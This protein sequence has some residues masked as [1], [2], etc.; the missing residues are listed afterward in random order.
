MKIKLSAIKEMES[1]LREIANQKISIRAAYRLMLVIEQINKC[2][3]QI[4]EMRVRLVRQ[5]GTMDEHGGV[6]VP[7]ENFEAFKND[8][9]DLLEEEV[10]I[11]F[12]KISMSEV[13]T[14]NISALDF[15]KVAVFFTEG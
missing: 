5:H 11:D 8:Y 6:Q 14:A 4:E 10:E 2:L 7:P 15:M 9:L 1:P 12:E 3:Q 13:E